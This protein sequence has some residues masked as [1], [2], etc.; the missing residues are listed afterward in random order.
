MTSLGHCVQAGLF[1]SLSEDIL[2]RLEKKADQYAHLITPDSCQANGIIDAL[3]FPVS[4][5]KE[6]I[7]YS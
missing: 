6:R 2:S 5:L 7:K 1:D 3:C 4:E